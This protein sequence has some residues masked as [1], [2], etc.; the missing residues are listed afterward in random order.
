MKSKL[1][2]F[3][4]L[5]SVATLNAAP[6]PQDDDTDE[7]ASSPVVCGFGELTTIEI[8]AD[9]PAPDFNDISLRF[10]I[11]FEELSA[12]NPQFEE[13]QGY[14]FNNGETVCAPEGYGAGRPLTIECD[15]DTVTIAIDSVTTTLESFALTPANNFDIDDLEAR[16]PHLGPFF[17]LLFAADEICVPADPTPTPTTPTPTPTPPTHHPRIPYYCEGKKYTVT[18]DDTLYEFSLS[19][20]VHL[21]NIMIANPQFAPDFNL[22]HPGDIVCIPISCFPHRQIDANEEAKCERVLTVVE[23]GDTLSQLANDHDLDLYS[24]ITANPHIKNPELIFPGDKICKPVGCPSYGHTKMSKKYKYKKD[25]GTED[26]ADDEEDEHYDDD[27]H[28]DGEEGT[29]HGYDLS[30]PAY[31]DSSARVANPLD[32]AFFGIAIILI[33]SLF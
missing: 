5:A 30:D 21:E 12:A 23:T 6:A 20:G 22:L 13:P 17:D 26:V 28:Y 10:N 2:I 4:A 27:E 24:L 19:N 9:A 7:T 3:L 33:L 11:L 31:L 29:A 15:G 8:P 25:D 1:A 16:N 32:S 18:K 14:I